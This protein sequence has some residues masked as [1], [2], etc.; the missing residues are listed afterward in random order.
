MNECE[1][2]YSQVSNKRECSFINFQHF[3]PSARFFPPCSFINFQTNFHPARLFHPCSIIPS[4]LLLPS[5]TARLFL[6]YKKKY[7]HPV[8][9]AFV[10]SF[11]TYTWL[12]LHTNLIFK[13]STLLNYQF[14]ENFHPAH[15]FHLCLIITFQENFHPARLSNFR[16]KFTLLVYSILLFYLILESS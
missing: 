5:C 4:C 2:K 8:L 16:K 6:F 9:L 12:S 14:S 1:S 15:L 13:N 11:L 3:A 10:Y 7:L